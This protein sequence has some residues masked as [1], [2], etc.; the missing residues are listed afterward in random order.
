MKKTSSDCKNIILCSVINPSVILIR[1]VVISLIFYSC[2]TSPDTKLKEASGYIIP[3][4]YLDEATD[5]PEFWIS[6]T[7]EISTF[8]ENNIK[9][10]SVEKIATSP[11]GRPVMAVF[12]GRKREGKGTTTFSGACGMNNSAPYRGPDH[13]K[14][15]YLGLG[16][17]HGFELEGIIGIV[18][19]I[20]VFETG[21]DLNLKRVA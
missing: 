10:G 9:K 4:G 8:L 6:T 5:I 19:L 12:Y 7:E 2:T 18:N 1:L 14:T 11:G 15:V 17:V 20:S 21:K 3:E 13:E 16:G